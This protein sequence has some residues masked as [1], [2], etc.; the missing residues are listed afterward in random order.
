VKRQPI[1]F[2]N[3]NL[4]EFPG[5]IKGSIA[6][7]GQELFQL[8]GTNV[9]IFVM[10][11]LLFDTVSNLWRPFSAK[12]LERLGGGELEIALLSA[13][14]GLVAAV[15]LLPGAMLFRRFTNKQR[16]TAMFIII[17]RALLLGIALVPALPASIRPMLFVVLV[18]IMNCPDALSQTSLQSFLGTVFGG[19]TRGQAIAMRTKFGQAIIPVVS[20]I[21]G[22]MITFLPNTEAQ[23][24]VL[25]QIFFVVAFLFGVL[26]VMMFSR[27]KVTRPDPSPMKES[28]SKPPSDLALLPIIIKDKRFLAFLVPAIT[29][30]FTWQ[31]GWP[32]VAIQQV[33]IIRATEMWFAI[34]AL[35]SGLAAFVS[36]GLWQLWLRKYGNNTVILISTAMLSVNMFLF[37]ITPNVQLMAL[38]SIFTGFSAIGINAS[39]LNG[40]LEATPDDNRMVYLAFYNTAVNISL[41]VAPF[42]A[43]ALLSRI[44]TQNAM[45]VVG[46][47]RVVATTFIWLV[48]RFRKIR[49][50]QQ[51]IECRF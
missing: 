50:L 1:R 6:S 41:F 13:L 24:I 5:R 46:F 44:G 43:H 10:Y 21:T 9:W 4:K 25:Y 20:I 45:F 30:L 26:E 8:R 28:A 29:F 19:N 38:L 36:G 35:A 7:V 49:A 14:P 11:G 16:A 12:F 37:P 42:F 23:R 15:V 18:A 17:S 31:A 2:S 27:L 51:G 34:F 48:F 32:L 39:L 33:M 47:M 40:V 3:I 22:L